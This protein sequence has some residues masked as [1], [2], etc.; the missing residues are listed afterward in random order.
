MEMMLSSGFCEMT[1][2]EMLVVDG[3]SFLGIVA[4][5][6][7]GT[8]VAHVAYGAIKGALAGTAVAPGVGTVIGVV[9]GIVLG[10]LAGTAVTALYDSF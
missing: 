5:A 10:G 8:G 1:Q 6:F 2:N 9:G 4:G 3:G 7:A